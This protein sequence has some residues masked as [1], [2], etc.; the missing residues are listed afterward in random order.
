[1][2]TLL[3][4]LVNNLSEGR[5]RIKSKLGHDD[6]KC[7]THRIKFKHCYCFLEYTNFKDDLIEQKCLRSS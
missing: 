4:N 5:H 6:K 3:T 7:E 1:M 2:A